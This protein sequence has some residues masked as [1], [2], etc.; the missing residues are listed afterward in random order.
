[1]VVFD[2]FLKDSSSEEADKELI[3]ALGG[4][5]PI[6]LA[7]DRIPVAHPR[8]RKH[9]IVPP[10]TNFLAVA[11]NWGIA[12]V[13]PDADGVIRRI[14][15]GTELHPSLPWAAAIL[16]GSL[17]TN[18]V[19][20]NRELPVRNAETDRWL[21]YYGPYGTIRGLSYHSAF[22][23]VD[24]YFRGKIVFVGGKPLT[25]GGELDEPD[26]FRTPY[27]R[28]DKRYTPGVEVLATMF[29]NLLHGDWLSRLSTGKELFL[30]VLAGCLFGFGLSVVR[31]LPGAGLAVAGI[32]VVTAIALW[33]FW[34]WNIWFTWVVIA[35]FQIPGAWICG[36]VTHSVRVSDEK[37][38]LEEELSTRQGSR[39]TEGIPFPEVPIPSARGDV[40]VH[41]YDLVRCI[42]K[43][44]F[45]EVWLARS[46]IG[47]YHAAKIIYRGDFTSNNSYARE[48]KGIEKYMPI[49]SGHPG[50]VQILHVGRNDAAGYYY[51]VM[52][53]GDDEND[54]QNIHPESYSPRNL[55]KD[56]HRRGR[57]PVP[58]CVALAI[59][60]ADALEFLHQQGLVHRDV[61]PSNIIFVKGAP[62][63]ADIGLV[64]DIVKPGDAMTSLGTLGYMA[65]EGPG[66][67]TADIY[68]L[69]KV[70]YVATM[71]RDVDDFPELA[72]SVDDSPESRT[73]LKLNS[74]VLKAC[75]ELNRRYQN[76]SEIRA[77]LV[78]L[79]G[80]LVAPR[81]H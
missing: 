64:A 25:P 72:T 29:L 26:E 1:M 45:G 66:K 27:T 65:P 67:P 38:V 68:S 12:A 76:A 69:G 52:E 37:R 55:S 74:I 75:D 60:L 11:P 10:W 42:G 61:K 9:T 13:D 31:P 57:I 24:G 71:G 70:L 17:S 51:C 20:E 46:A 78:K 54:G 18:S 40:T 81:K 73:L 48:F 4:F 59:A 79:R 36:L 33:L 35:G 43:G 5:N 39:K 22:D 16:A 62:K 3:R 19:T 47:T 2:V 30:I 8:L 77:D 50:L 15:P 53:C 49:S 41:N 34:S 63:L 21:R 23:Q 32:L 44:A 14:Y 80:E 58:E 28:W 6:V 7:A 56:L